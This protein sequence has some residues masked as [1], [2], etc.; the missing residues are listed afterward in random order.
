MKKN[1][2]LLQD[3]EWYLPDDSQHWNKLKV[4]APSF[5]NLGVTL[6]WLPPAIKELVEYMM[7]DMVSMIYTILES[8]IKRERFLQNMARNKN[9]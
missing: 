9:I 5:S 8:L 3:F 1:D 6:V 2:T 7:W 4:Q